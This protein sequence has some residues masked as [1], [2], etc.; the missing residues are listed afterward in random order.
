LLRAPGRGGRG[1]AQRDRD[2]AR[3]NRAER[4]RRTR[5]RRD[6]SGENRD[7]IRVDP[8]GLAGLPSKRA[9]RGRPRFRERFACT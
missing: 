3:R 8:A 5:T 9:D 7:P 2:L 6:R 4:S 1:D